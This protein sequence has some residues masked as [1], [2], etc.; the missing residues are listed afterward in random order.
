MADKWERF[1]K[2]YDDEFEPLKA[3]LNITIYGSYF[4]NTEKTFLEEQRNY[5][6]TRG[7]VKTNI[8]DD[9][10]DLDSNSTPLEKSI[11]CLEFSDV[12][13]LIF[14]RAGKAQGVS[15]ELTHIATS[16]SMLDKIPFCTVFDQ[17]RDNIGSVSVLSLNDIENTG[18]GRREF[19]N[20]AQL[21]DRLYQQ[22]VAKLRMKKNIL[23]KDL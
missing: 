15:R 2:K 14:T 12:N 20:E 23:R 19:E 10:D 9:F 6:R 1:N 22:A 11:R 3:L 16:E 5:L 18:I 7:F 8:V 21:R 13:F 17:M 4:P